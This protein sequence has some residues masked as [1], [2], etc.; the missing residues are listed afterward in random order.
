M[1]LAVWSPL[2]PSP[3]GIAD[4]VAES[5][6]PLS[7]HHE[8]VLVTEDPEAVDGALR[9]RLPVAAAA[10]APEADLDLHHL[11]NSPS[12]GFVYRAARERP[13]VVVLHDWTL[14]HLVLHETVQKGDARTYLREM[15]RAHGE[16]GTFVG[17]QVAR[18]LGGA[19][20][21]ALFPLNDRVL[22]ASL[23]V[24]ALS[25]QTADRVRRKVPGRAVLHL[26]HHLSLPAP[27]PSRGEARRRLGLS[28]D[29]LVVTA[30]GLATAAKRLDVALR[31]VARLKTALPRLRLV[32]AGGVDPQLP[33]AAWVRAHGLADSCVVTGRL[34]LDD[35]VGH[36]AAADVVLALRFPSH[37]EMSGAL[38]RALGVG[39]PVLVSAG[40]AAADEFADG[41]VVTV[42]PGPAEEAELEAL[43]AHLLTQP[44]LRD[45][46]GALA[47]EHVRR[48]HD[49]DAT[50]RRLAGFLDEVAAA[51]PA[52]LAARRDD[53]PPEDGLLSFFVEEVRWGAR[54]LGLA[55]LRLGL[56]PLLA[57]LTGRTR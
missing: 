24:V 41:V 34:S 52:L 20:L 45:R 53:H 42:D 36:L 31:V 32:V 9:V 30:P 5:V 6:I 18:A 4:Y 3:S 23:G 40:S 35:F 1:K 44:S 37:G 19:L 55:D 29:D 17:R 13:G 38:V 7:R 51:K 15:R 10:S 8:V 39:R 14:H 16:A 56:E 26:P 25:R 47:R 12:H 57:P 49:L 54:D 46:I 50:A 22:E 33:L 11:G 2:P 28:D 27:L 43:L 21:P 48:E